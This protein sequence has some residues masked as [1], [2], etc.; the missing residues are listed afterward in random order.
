MAK[1]TVGLYEEFMDADSTL[2][3]RL[4]K[5]EF[6]EI[7]RQNLAARDPRAA[8]QILAEGGT[9]EEPLDIDYEVFAYSPVENSKSA[10]LQKIEKF[11]QQ[12][13]GNPIIDQQKLMKFLLESLDVP[14]GD[15]L[16]QEAPPAPAPGMGGGTPPPMGPPGSTPPVG[17]IPDS[18]GMLSG[19]GELPPGVQ[20]PPDAGTGARVG[21]AGGAGANGPVV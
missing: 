1:A 8:E 12:L 5:A 17:G 14:D 16:V 2:P 20:P 3:V 7:A 4:G 11:A 13:F 9:I 21:M 19:G 10:L 6:M 18:M 15:D